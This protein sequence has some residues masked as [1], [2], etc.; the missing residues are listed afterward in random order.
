MD[1]LTREYCMPNEST[2]IHGMDMEMYVC[3]YYIHIQL[4]KM[5]STNDEKKF[6]KDFREKFSY[7]ACS[8]PSRPIF[9]PYQ[10]IVIRQ[11]SCWVVYDLFSPNCLYIDDFV[12]HTAVSLIYSY[13]LSCID[14]QRITGLLLQFNIICV[15][16]M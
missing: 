1:P 12:S 7:S 15:Y 11:G 4:S 16:A 13:I 8:G 2:R 5:A 14:K 6:L 9:H 10:N 3:M